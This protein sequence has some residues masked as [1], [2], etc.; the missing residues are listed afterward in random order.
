MNNNGPLKLKAQNH[1]GKGKLDYVIIIIMRN[2]YL[3][4]G[5]NMTAVLL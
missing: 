3:E 5:Q 4:R 1:E 2:V